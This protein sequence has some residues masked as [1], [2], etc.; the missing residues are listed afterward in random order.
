MGRVTTGPVLEGAI[1][2]VNAPASALDR[3][4]IPSGGAAGRCRSCCQGLST[5][6][7]R[8]TRQVEGDA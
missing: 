8:G 2:A 3:Q 7:G 4:A 1:C 5:S 6:R